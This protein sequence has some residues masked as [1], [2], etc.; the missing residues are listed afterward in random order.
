MLK[1]LRFPVLLLLAVLLTN[2]A[3]AGDLRELV[4]RDG[5]TAPQSAARLVRQVPGQR[6]VAPLLYLLPSL[7]TKA[8]ATMEIRIL[9]G[10]RQ[11]IS[12][13]V[14]L[15]PRLPAGATVDVLFT[16]ADD[17]ARLRA[18]ETASPGSLRFLAFV[19]GRAVTDEPLAAIEARGAPLSPDSAVGEVFEVDVR[20]A[21]KSHIHALDE[22][23]DYCDAQ[24]TSC[25]DWCDQRS[26]SCQQCWVDY[27]SCSSSCTPSC[28]EPRST[29][30]YTTYTILTVSYFGENVC[31]SPY[32]PTIYG[33]RYEH[34]YVTMRV[35]TFHRV[36]HC[37][38]SHTDTQTSQYD[39]SYWCWN[40]THNQCESST[41]IAPNPQC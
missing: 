13:I 2:V 29:S 40:N 39:T 23:T 9:Q 19:E 10:T 26:N 35:T 41:G 1:A 31:Y 7:G 27:Q 30:D 32:H 15:P 17:L 34:L 3:F 6:Q 20:P 11:L 16:H 28:T 12:E 22:C 24:Y 14:K 33:E 8:S 21:P 36:E 5:G 38:G 18:I 37:D 4:S 25:L